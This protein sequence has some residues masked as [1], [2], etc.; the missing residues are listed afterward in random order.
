MLLSGVLPS[1]LSR[2]RS[3]PP[4]SDESLNP[5]SPSKRT[6]FQTS[7][8]PTEE[9]TRTAPYNQLAIYKVGGRTSLSFGMAKLST[10]STILGAVL[11]RLQSTVKAWET[12]DFESNLQ[13]GG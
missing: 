8:V 2:S 11:V 12:H 7:E 3:I 10:T 5:Q 6:N 9:R 13:S 1:L 4:S